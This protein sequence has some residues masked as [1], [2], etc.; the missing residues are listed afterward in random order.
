MRK[1]ISS[2]VTILVIATACSVINTLQNVSRLKYKIGSVNNYKV[3]GVTV[4]NKTK[5]KDFS[6]METLKI[7]GALLKGSLP[8]TFQLNIEAVN[9]NDGTGGKPRTD[10]T[11]ESF[12]WRLFIND[13]ETIT[14][15]ISQPISVPGV[16]ESTVIPIEIS[17]DIAKNFKE[18]NMDDILSFALNLSGITKSQSNLKLLVKPVIGTPIGKLQYPDEITVVD[19]TFN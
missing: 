11:I 17:F 13:K 15:N 3:A 10:L 2:V 7:S 14:G 12:P 1:L 16:G 9:P 4:E 5:L 6:T 8:V 18:K 19:K